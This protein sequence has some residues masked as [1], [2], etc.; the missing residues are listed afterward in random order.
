[1]DPTYFT[2]KQDYPLVWKLLEGLSTAML[3][4]YLLAGQPLFT[5][6]GLVYSVHWLA[7]LLYHLNPSENTFLV[8][9]H[10]IDMVSMERVV[11][12]FGAQWLY[13]L[14]SVGLLFHVNAWHRWACFCKIGV[15]VTAIIVGVD[16]VT[17]WYLLSW[18]VSAITF[19]LSSYAYKVQRFAWSVALHVCFHLS[20]GWTTYLEPAYYTVTRRGASQVLAY[21]WYFVYFL[22]NYARS[23]ITAFRASRDVSGASETTLLV[24]QSDEASFRP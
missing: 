23:W 3:P 24:T 8:D 4:G 11:S 6:L 13:L 7:S 15:I 16:R 2:H 18:V 19:V 9:T 1:M 17:V 12:L 21:T 22:W 14:Y 20:L 10:F 5:G